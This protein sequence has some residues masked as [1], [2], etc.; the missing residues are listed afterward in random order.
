MIALPAF[1]SFAPFP[2][3]PC[4]ANLPIPDQ[5]LAGRVGSL[6]HDSCALDVW[7][8]YTAVVLERG[9]EHCHASG[10]CLQGSLS[11][12]KKPVSS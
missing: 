11:F 4:E 9:G 6:P 7:E 12:A 1:C 5:T 2:H 8:L 3:P 10:L